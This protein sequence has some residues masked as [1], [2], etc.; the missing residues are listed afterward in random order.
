[1]Q[2]EEKQQG[3]LSNCMKRIKIC[4]RRFLVNSAR[5]KVSLNFQSEECPWNCLLVQYCYI[6]IAF[7]NRLAHLIL[8]YQSCLSAKNAPTIFNHPP[9]PP[10][11]L[12]CHNGCTDLPSFLNR[13]GLIRLHLQ[14]ITSTRLSSPYSKE[15]ELRSL[16]T[17][18]HPV[19][20]YPE[21]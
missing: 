5:I 21:A 19:Q 18:N 12:L 7:S 14:P 13:H 11:Y 6:K 16:P 10:L 3:C 20:S 2:G 15:H 17:Q 9:K 4:C 8:V 1:V